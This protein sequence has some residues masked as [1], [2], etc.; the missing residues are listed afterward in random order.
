MNKPAGIHVLYIDGE[1]DVAKEAAD[2]LSGENDRFTVETIPSVSESLD[3]L[4]AADF[5]CLVSEYQ[6]P[7]KNGIEFLETVREKYPELPFILYTAS[8]TEAIAAEAISLDVTDYLQKELGT[9][10][11]TILANR[12]INAVE[13]YRSQ[14]LR[15]E[16]NQDLLRY[17]WMVNS[18]QEAAC[19]YD[20]DGRFELVNEYLAEWYGTTREALKGESSNLI[21][22]VREDAVDY[23]CL[24]GSL[25]H[26]WY[27]PRWRL[28]PDWRAWGRQCRAAAHQF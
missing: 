8:G 17:E 6:L 21:A 1:P 27:S 4:E 26:S 22:H 20:E 18:M 9:D 13:S 2:M 12:I 16:G 11:Y 25:R 23:V 14:Q 7:G 19:I 10:Q 24:V 3:R 28:D 5:D 15:P